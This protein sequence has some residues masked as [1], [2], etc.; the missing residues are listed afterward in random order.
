ME[1][2][3]DK[4]RAR[5]IR[6]FRIRK[7]VKGTAENPRLAVFKSL[8]HTYV[9]AVDDLNGTTLVS[10]STLDKECKGQIKHGG[11]KEAAKVIGV[12]VAQRLKEKG[13]TKVVFDRSGYLYHG[14]VKILAKAVRDNGLQF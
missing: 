14:R 4:N 2:K 3:K 12:I 6:K 1:A 5:R 10:A 8:K 7:K 13:I 11:N 9:Q